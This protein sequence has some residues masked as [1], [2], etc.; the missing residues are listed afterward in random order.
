MES[1]RAVRY[2]KPT[3]EI[4]TVGFERT[5]GVEQSP[6]QVPA[7]PPPYP[8]TTTYCMK[9]ERLEVVDAV[10]E[11]HPFVLRRGELQSAQKWETPLGCEVRG[12]TEDSCRAHFIG[13][14]RWNR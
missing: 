1:G 14:R 7:L 2:E 10:T 13:G 4:T 11:V 6:S 12:F 5:A 8:L 3:D 9:H